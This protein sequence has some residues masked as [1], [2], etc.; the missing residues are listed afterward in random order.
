VNKQTRQVRL[1]EEKTALEALRLQEVDAIIGNNQV[2]ILR[3]QQVDQ[4]LRRQAQIIQ[5]IHDAVIVT[6]LECKITHWN[7][8]ATRLYG[9]SALEVIGQHLFL[10]YFDEDLPVLYDQVL[11]PLQTG[12]ALEID[13]RCR[14]KTGE[15]SFIR[16]SVSLLQDEQDVASGL[17]ICAT[18]ITERKQAEAERERLLADLEHE[19]MQLRQLNQTLN[20][21]VQVQTQ[22]VRNL[23]AELSL[24]ENRERKRIAQVLHDHVQQLLYGLQFLN[25]SLR[26]DAN[27]GQTVC[28]AQVDDLLKQAVEATRTLSIEL[29]PPVLE[30]RGLTD[31]LAWLADEMKRMHGLQVVLDLQEDGGSINKHLQVSTFQIIR[32]LLFN[33]VKHA[34]IDKADIILRQTE[35]NLSITVKDEGQGVDVSNLALRTDAAGFGLFSVRDRV[36]LFGGQMELHSAPGAGTQVSLSFPLSPDISE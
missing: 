16:L 13:A 34:R 15:A 9:Y 19:R 2:M 17:I 4:A 7:L 27:P 31:G 10:L 23:A 33:V 36:D 8:G 14:C 1:N 22:Q 28:L 3:Q 35:S 5:Q 29:S 6:D 25:Q 26:L 20:Q 18:D 24:A 30:T 21:Q 32:E 11:T 12:K